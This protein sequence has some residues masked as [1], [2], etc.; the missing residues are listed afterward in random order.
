MRRPIPIYF[1]AALC[2]LHIGGLAG[3]FQKQ[4]EKIGAING[5]LSA[6]MALL[7]YLVLAI[8]IIQTVGLIKLNNFNRWFAII[9]FIYQAFQ[10]AVMSWHFLPA[11]S[12]PVR[13]IIGSSLFI[14]LDLLAAWYLTR[15]SFRTFAIEYRAFAIDCRNKKM[16]KKMMEKMYKLSKQ[17]K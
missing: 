13:T 4:S 10:M 12:N 14:I 6:L 16:T 5:Q 8:A 3:L 1:I 15:P 2:F 7:S 9:L 11:S 17:P